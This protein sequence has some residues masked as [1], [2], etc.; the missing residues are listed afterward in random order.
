MPRVTTAFAAAFALFL[1]IGRPLLVMLTPAIGIGS[2]LLT[3]HAAYA[4]NAIDLYNSGIDKSES[5][6]L[7]GAI[8]DWTKAI[9]IYPRFTYA[10]YNRAIAKHELQD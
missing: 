9:E 5:G 6:N 3:T 1:P 4:Q 10:Y 7:E 8:A 2:G